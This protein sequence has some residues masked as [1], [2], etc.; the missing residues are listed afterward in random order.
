MITLTE[1]QEKH[2]DTVRWLISDG[3]RASGRTYILSVAYLEKAFKNIG[4]KIVVSDHFRS[5]M[6]DR[7]LVN[8]IIRLFYKYDLCET[9][10]IEYGDAWVKVLLK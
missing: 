10:Y 5:I 4:M 9:Y 6:S 3:N 2:L 1:Q 8:E 7:H